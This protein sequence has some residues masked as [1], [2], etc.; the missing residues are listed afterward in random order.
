VRE[1]YLGPATVVVTVVVLTL[2]FDLVDL[3]P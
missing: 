2:L 1:E 3:R